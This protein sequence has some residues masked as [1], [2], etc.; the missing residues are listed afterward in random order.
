M[1][2]TD[3]FTEWESANKTIAEK[4]AEIDRLCVIEEAAEAVL[5]S[6]TLRISG[7][8][9]VKEIKLEDFQSFAKALE[10]AKEVG[11]E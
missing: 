9:I 4:D 3:Y 5:V 11:D 10:P 7:G 6:R 1:S 2:N 8:T